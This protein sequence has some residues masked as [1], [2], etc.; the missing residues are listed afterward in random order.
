MTDSAFAGASL[1]ESA[2]D[3]KSAIDSGDWA[4]G[5]LAAAGAGLDAEGVVVGMVIELTR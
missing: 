4:A 2:T 1:L 3:L 5:A